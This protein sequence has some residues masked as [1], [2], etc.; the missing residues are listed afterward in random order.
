MKL[1]DKVKFIILLVVFL[2]LA[3]GVGAGIYYLADEVFN[4]SVLEWLARNFFISE[5]QYDE[6]TRHVAIS[7]APTGRSSRGCFSCCSLPRWW[8]MCSPSI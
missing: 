5:P 6:T 2:G 1:K 7:T 4:G 3:V 8:S